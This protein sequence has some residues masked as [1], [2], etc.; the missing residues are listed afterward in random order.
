MK[1]PSL[2]T[3]LSIATLT[4]LQAQEPSTSKQVD[5]ATVTKEGSYAFGAQFGSNFTDEEIDIEA[6]VQGFKDKQ[7]GETKVSE[8]ELQAHFRR[9]QA[10]LDG[11]RRAK[12]EAEGAENLTKAEAFLKEN[13]AKEGVKT[14]ASGLQYKVEKEGSGAAP[15]AVDQ[16]KV[17]YHGTLIDGTVFDSSVDK[18]KPAEFALNRVIKGWTEG[19]QLVK[20]GGKTRFFIHPDLA[21]GKNARNKIPANSALIFDVELL[22]VK[23]APA[24]KPSSTRPS[25]VSPP[26]K[27]PPRKK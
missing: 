4:C 15:K 11:K 25:A 9:L 22:E 17:H 19:L 1:A 20:P 26:V 10:D 8:E 3:I 7:T 24:K 6:F 12:K 21:Y 18:G 5:A 14:T 2:L 27:I 23:P 13:A 16:V